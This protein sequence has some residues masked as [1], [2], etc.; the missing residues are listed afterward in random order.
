MSSHE[1]PTVPGEPSSL[2]IVLPCR[3]E[4]GNVVRVV[5]EALA[6]GRDV[7]S[8]VEVIVVDDGSSDATAA[9]ADELARE[10]SRVRVVRHPQNRGYGAALRSG[11]AAAHGAWVF[12]TDGDGQLSLDDLRQL[13]AALA[14]CDAVVGY[15][16]A[17]Q[18]PLARRCMG[19]VWTT[20]VNWTFGLDLVD[21]DCAF[22]IFPREFLQRAELSST[23]ALISAELVARAKHHGLRVQ[24]IAVGHRPRIAGQP[25][26][27]HPR[28][29][30]RAFRELF[31]LRRRIRSQAR[32]TAK[33]RDS[34]GT[35]DRR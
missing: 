1:L 23:G 21:A 13:P 33:P 20:V 17:R 10:D 34:Q 11:F 6:R 24:Q 8:Q 19:H 35:E 2:S 5:G 31:A 7:A 26:G 25:T 29:I 15:R 27:A 14:T 28:V 16:R 12:Y 9:L 22:K 4:A 3:N 18:D 30:A 32:A